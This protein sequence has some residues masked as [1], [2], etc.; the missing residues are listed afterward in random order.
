MAEV[1]TAAAPEGVLHRRIE[2]HLARRPHA[3]V[4]AGGSGFRME[5]LNPQ[6][7]GKVGAPAAAGSGE[8]GTRRSE[9]GNAGVIDPELSVARIYLGRI[10]AGLQNLGNTC[11]LN[12]VLQCLTYTEPFAAYLQSGKH[13][14][15]CHTSGFCALCALQNHVKMALQSTGKIVTP[16]NIVKNL[17]CISRSFRNS[18]QEDAHELMVNLL[19]SMHKCCLPSGVPSESQSAYEKSLVHKIFGG[20]L[21]SQVKCTRCL[22]CSNKFDPFLDLSLDIAKATTLVRAL[23]NFTEEELLDGGKKQYQC[24]RCRQKV[25]AKKRF[26]IDKAPNVLTV[27]LKRFSPFNPREKIDKKV[28]FQPVLDLKPFVSDSKGADFKY[29]LYGVLVHAGWNTQSGHYFCFVRTSSGMWHNLDD[30]QVRQ[31][32]EAD[33]LRQKAYMLFYVRDSIGN[34]VVRRDNSTANLTTKRTPEK[35]STLIGITQGSVKAEHLNGSSPFGDKTHSTSNGYSSIFGKTSGDHFSKNEVKAENAAASQ[36]NGLPSTQAL[37]PRNDGVTLPAKSIQCSVNGQDTSSSHQPLS[38]A[39]ISGKQTVAGRSLQEVE[40]KAEAGKST[41]VASPMVNGAGT[42]SKADKLTSQRQTTP[43]SKPTA[44]VNDTSAG[45]TAQTSLKKDSIVS[46]GVVPGSGS[47][48]S[49]E[50]AKDLPGSVEQAND[51]VMALPISQNNTAPEL[52]QVKCGQQISSG[53]SVQVAVAASCNGT[54][55]QK[56]NFKSKK[57]VR[58]PVVNMWLGS[59]Q[60]L[61]ASLKAGKKTKHKRTRRRLV[62]CKDVANISC[63]GDNMNEQ[64]TSTSAT[65][66]SEAV[67]CTSGRRKHSHASER[68]ENYTQSS[69]NKQKVNGACVD[70]ETNAPSANADIPKSGSSSSIDQAQSRK[71]ED[72]TVPQPV[73]IR[74]SDLME[75]TVPCWDDIDMPNTKV[76]EWQHPKR[77]NNIGYVLDKW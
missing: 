25:V 76:A 56:A 39:Y 9:K 75:A 36:S 49:S 58:Y 64:L 6:A 12:S 47:L 60:L 62:D 50:K 35:T 37:G 54:T 1:S 21:R 8:G 29:S 57:F 66:Q 61:V 18:R 13:K 59:K 31:V 24:E 74:A 3:A 23:Q 40:P 11:Y 69:E 30:N 15:S 51:I 44:P 63:L 33:V 17:R 7:A 34:P 48:T 32:R 42:L 46:N 73:S 10:G 65:A 41:S 72:A 38:I 22:H 45:F 68:P 52:A 67:E 5:T 43:L 55:A 26:T 20:R 4:T 53:G 27:H 2:F 14:S 28:D 70:T 19:E 16:S 71:H 77:K